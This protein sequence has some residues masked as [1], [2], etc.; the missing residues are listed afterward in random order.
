[1]MNL[2]LR[3][4]SIKLQLLILEIITL[5]VMVLVIVLNYALAAQIL[6]QNNKNYS[7]E[8]FAQA[9]RNVSDNCNLL[10]AMLTNAAYNSNVQ[11]FLKSTSP[12]ETYV[13]FSNVD[14]LIN[15]LQALKSDSIIDF[16][17]VGNNG[18][19]YFQNG[20]N[21]SALALL[22][23]LPQHGLLN[24][25]T[26]RVEL[27]YRGIKKNC[28]VLVSTIYAIEATI[29]KKEEI[30]L[31]AIVVDADLFS[32]SQDQNDTQ[33]DTQFYLLDRNNV[34]YASVNPSLPNNITVQLSNLP[35][36]ESGSEKITA[37]GVVYVVN[38]E[39]VAPVGGRI[40]SIIAEK[41]LLKDIL[42]I[43]KLAFVIVG[44]T[45]ILMLLPYAVIVNNI[46]TPLNK[47]LYFMQDIKSGSLAE[48]K[49]RI[50]VTG[51]SEME[52]MSR[53][54]N[55]MLDEIAEL[56]TSLVRTN[57]QLYQTE[58]AKKRSEI[59][60]LKSQINP[61]FLYNTL[62][63]MI[64]AAYQENAPETARMIKALVVIFRYSVKGK[65]FVQ[66]AEEVDI[67]KSYIVIQQIRFAGKFTVK[68]Q[69]EPETL[70]CMIPKVIL[71]PLVENAIFYG[72]ETKMEPG[73][74]WIG[75]RLDEQGD[76]GLWVHDD[77]LGIAN[78]QLQEIRDTLSPDE[79]D[80]ARDH[81]AQGIGI[82][83][84]HER[85]RLI[86]GKNY[87]LTIDSEPNRGT[88]VRIRLPAYKA[89]DGMPAL[90]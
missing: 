78:D 28:F 18:N 24:Y 23:S 36:Q 74:L 63:T 8:Y 64:G 83:N 21:P 30:G 58:L 57:T 43:R 47:F 38:Y 39:T 5:V 59:A 66:L 85:I 20:L 86:Y 19:R 79:Y 71:Q 42:W 67:I 60:Y 68:Y 56:T 40:V 54:F 45:L 44:I 33:S 35:H 31:A 70:A 32:F 10:S 82:A 87:G 17:I 27:T 15:S 51:Y 69:F 80:Q 3:R 6:N 48:L 11:K 84:V 50:Y 61:H 73:N 76:L 46:L 22:E 34:P 65:D 9:K 37:G 4:L 26:G 52:I 41:D 2:S 88:W 72:L 89:V 81:P 12:S 62:E 90:R 16:A 75:S 7:T 29:I 14:A 53:E 49:K 25:Y 77:G 55:H 13:N 1:M